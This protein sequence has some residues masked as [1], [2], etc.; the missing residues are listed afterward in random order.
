MPFV[1]GKKSNT[2]ITYYGSNFLTCAFECSHVFVS[3]KGLFGSN[4][5]SFTFKYRIIKIYVIF[6]ELKKS[7]YLPIDRQDDRPRYY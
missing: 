1:S 3:D 7:V 4:F 6:L 2:Q 5:K